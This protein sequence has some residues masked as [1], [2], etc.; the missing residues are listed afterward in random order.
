MTESP[1]R[2]PAFLTAGSE[3]LNYEDLD[4][5]NKLKIRALEGLDSL[6][7]SLNAISNIQAI[8]FQINHLNDMTAGFTEE[9]NQ[10]D[11][12]IADLTAQLS[13]LESTQ[14]AQLAALQEA[15][16]AQ[17]TELQNTQAAN[18]ALMEAE[19][20]SLKAANESLT[21]N[22]NKFKAVLTNIDILTDEVIS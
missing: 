21:Q 1:Y 22:F 17:L 18:T 5:T 7:A 13:T 3:T 11:A 16:A 15:Q 14:A 2:T 6:A 19:I 8:E 9:M 12:E 20:N 10:K 4:Y